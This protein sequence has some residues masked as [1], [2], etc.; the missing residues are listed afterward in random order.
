MHCYTSYLINQTLNG[1]NKIKTNSNCGGY[2]LNTAVGL[3]FY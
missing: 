1:S 2:K 3:F